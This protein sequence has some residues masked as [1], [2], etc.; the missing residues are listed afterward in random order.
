LSNKS[1][2]FFIFNKL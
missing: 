1:T 2:R